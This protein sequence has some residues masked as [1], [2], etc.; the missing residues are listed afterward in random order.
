MQVNIA[1]KSIGF[2]GGI[3][4]KVVISII[5]VV[6]MHLLVALSLYRKSS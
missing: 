6:W 5:T 2:G 3:C 4:Q 1:S